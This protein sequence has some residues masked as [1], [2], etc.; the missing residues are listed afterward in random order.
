M[1]VF[2]DF[3]HVVYIRYATLGKIRM[4]FQMLCK[5]HVDLHTAP[6]LWNIGCVYL[7]MCVMF[8]RMGGM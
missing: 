3:L 7:C 2:I 4:C 8:A 1:L 5:R 6:F